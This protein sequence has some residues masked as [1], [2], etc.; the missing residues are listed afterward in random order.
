M[1]AYAAALS[2][3]VLSGP[4]LFSEVLQ[5]AMAKASQPASQMDQRYNV[6]V[7]LT[8]GIINDMREVKKST[9]TIH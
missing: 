2:S 3:V 9:E 4:T 6:L 5:T 1:D 7:I 8:D